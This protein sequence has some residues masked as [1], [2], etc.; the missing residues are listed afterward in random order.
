MSRGTVSDLPNL[1]IDWSRAAIDASTV[2][3]PGGTQKPGRIQLSR[4]KGSG[5]SFC[6]K[7]HPPPH[8]STRQASTPDLLPPEFSRRAAVWQKASEASFGVRSGNRT[9]RNKRLTLCQLDHLS[10]AN[11][12]FIIA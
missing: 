12:T 2:P 9:L 8:S 7:S 10:S 6:I 1:L 3:A 5:L 4:E 11:C